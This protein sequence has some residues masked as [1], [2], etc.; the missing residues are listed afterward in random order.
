[1]EALARRYEMDEAS[2]FGDADPFESRF[3]MRFDDFADAPL[4]DDAEPADAV[5]AAYASR[6]SWFLDEVTNEEASLAIQAAR[7]ARALDHARSWAMLSDEFVLPNAKLT[8]REREDWVLRVFVSEVA[9]R[10]RL[11]ESTA[12]GL[13]DES[14]VLVHELSHTLDALAAAQISH[15]HALVII[16]QS[17]TLPAHVRTSFELSVLPD[18]KRLPVTQFRRRAVSA[19]ERM[20][21][22]SIQDRTR[23]A[24]S[25][26][27][28]AFEADVDGMAW[29]HHLLPAPDARAI[30]TRVT[31]IATSLRGDEEHRT[32]AQLRSDVAAELLLDG[33]PPDVAGGDGGGTVVPTVSETKRR[34]AFGI[35][36]TVVVI[37]PALTAFGLGDD[38]GVLDDYGLIDPQTA[39]RLAGLAPSW[40]RLFTDPVTGAVLG[41]GKKRYK[42]PKD[43]RTWLE[44]RDETCRF[45]GCGRPASRTDIDHTEDWAK[46]GSTD[47]GNLA[48]LCEPH[49]LMKHTTMWHVVQRGNGVLDWRS[50]TGQVH[51]TRPA[52]ELQ[53][54]SPPKT[55]LSNTQPVDPPVDP[56]DDPPF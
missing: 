50:P 17:R 5:S 1:M 40:L 39:R 46:G 18:A 47:A 42:V 26:R 7:R 38:P 53:G 48:C 43:L 49:H 33:V 52:L 56:P 4:P 22:E 30:Y 2:V 12:G 37:L 24:V 15:R 41:L 44:L 19:R 27:R 45:P 14:R 28:F 32:L 11:P 25:D 3:D 31:D 34:R 9:T 6:L 55:H 10:L 21:P 35:R 29:L 36:P 20:H 23:S 8:E 16:E 13:V 54:S 51:T